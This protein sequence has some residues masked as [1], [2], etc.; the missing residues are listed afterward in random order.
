MALDAIYCAT[1]GVAFVVFRARLGG[2]LGLP[3]VLVASAGAA[4]AGWSAVVLGQTVRIDWRAA[5]KQT[6]AANAL[7]AA[8]LGLG[9]ALHPVRGARALL[10]VTA[11][12]VASF[13]VALV[14]SL[15]RRPR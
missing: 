2:L 9:A 8:L 1:V 11:L 13:P 14:I 6:A 10:V 7:I 12:E 4:T 15:V 3:P 5:A